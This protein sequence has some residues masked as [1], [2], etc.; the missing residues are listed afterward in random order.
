MSATGRGK[1]RAANDFYETPARCVEELMQACDLGGANWLEPSAGSGA[2]IRAVNAIKPGITWAA[3]ELDNRHSSNLKALTNNVHVGS[4][5]TWEKDRHY[6]V[7]IGNPPYSLAMEFVQT[8]LRNADTVALLLRLCF[9]AS[10]KR[11]DFMMS[12]CPDVYVLSQRPSFTGGGTDST[13]YAWFVWH[14]DK[15]TTRGSF[16]VIGSNKRERSD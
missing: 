3:V 7:V 5:L 14:S 16:Q 9:A 8:S 6:D 1:E 4:Y 15:P 12:T 10:K 13:D 11:A 2:I